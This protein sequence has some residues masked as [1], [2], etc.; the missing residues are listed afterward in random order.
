MIHE[1][2]HYSIRARRIA[3]IVYQ[4]GLIAE[5]E[6]YIESLCVLAEEVL[7]L[8][9]L[10]HESCAVRVGKLSKRVGTFEG[11]NGSLIFVIL[12]D[13]RVAT[14]LLRRETQR[15]LAIDFS[16]EKVYTLR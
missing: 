9:G 4:A 13:N 14:I 12:R 5:T 7:S 3:T 15:C 11:R 6:P 2:T 8:Y 10:K 16:V 1:H